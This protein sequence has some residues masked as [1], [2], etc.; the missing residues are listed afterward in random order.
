M[1]V[2]YGA[3]PSEG[4]GFI[5]FRCSSFYVILCGIIQ[6]EP[7]LAGRNPRAGTSHPCGFDGIRVKW[8]FVIPCRANLTTVVAHIFTINPSGE[9]TP[10]IA[11]E[12][13][14]IKSVPALILDKELRTG[15]LVILTSRVSEIFHLNQ[16][17]R[18]RILGDG[19]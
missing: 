18:M 9:S 15:K 3:P 14:S 17:R 10:K 7:V 4:I 16:W 5:N 12:P 13:F 8:W 6:I 11:G 19:E 2:L 1:P